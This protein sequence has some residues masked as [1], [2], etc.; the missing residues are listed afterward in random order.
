MTDKTEKLLDRFIDFLPVAFMVH[1]IEEAVGM[2]AWIKSIPFCNYLSVTTAQFIIAAGLFT[3]LGF[4]LVFA[5]KWYSSGP[6]FTFATTGF[7]GMLFLN[8]FF[9]HLI[10]TL[11]FGKYAPGVIS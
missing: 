3:A 9:P 7:A 8:V 10:A 5:K 6:Q 2:E 1:N 4:I 11:I